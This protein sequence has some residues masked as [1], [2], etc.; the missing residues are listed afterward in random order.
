MSFHGVLCS[1]A[2]FFFAFSGYGDALVRI[3]TS[4]DPALPPQGGFYGY[5][6]ASTGPGDDAFR[7]VLDLAEK[8]HV[9]LFI[10][11]AKD[12]CGTCNALLNDLNEWS[13][14]YPKSLAYGKTVNGYFRGK[15][16]GTGPKACVEA[17]NFLKSTLGASGSCHIMGLYGVCG[18]GTL[19]KKTST[20]SSDYI[21]FGKW[22]VAQ[23]DAFWKLAEQ[24]PEVPLK[25]SADFAVGTNVL[26]A[27]SDTKSVYVPFVRTNN[28]EAAE[29]NWVVAT[30]PDGGVAT[31]DLQWAA[32]DTNLEVEIGMLTN[33]A[34]A[35]IDGGKVMLELLNTN[36]ISVATNW[37]HF[38]ATPETGFAN[39]VISAE[40]GK[41]NFGEWTL[42]FAAATGKVY[43]ANSYIQPDTNR[44]EVVTN[45]VTYS[46]VI[47]NRY[48]TVYT[49]DV[50]VF[51]D[52]TEV[53]STNWTF[54]CVASN[55]VTCIYT[56]NLADFGEPVTEESLVTVTIPM[57]NFTTTVYTNDITGVQDKSE[58]IEVPWSFE[59]GCKTNFVINAGVTNQFGDAET[60]TESRVLSA[61]SHTEY[62]IADENHLAGT[63]VVTTNVTEEVIELTG[64]NYYYT[65]PS[66]ETK[67][68]TEIFTRLIEPGTNQ[69]YMVVPGKDGAAA[70]TNL[71]SCE[72]S[73]HE[74]SITVTET[75]HKLPVDS[76]HPKGRETTYLDE[77]VRTE[78]FSVP[79]TI[80]YVTASRDLEPETSE[81][82]F[83]ETLTNRLYY[84]FADTGVTNECV[85]AR[86]DVSAEF[87]AT[88]TNYVHM[89]WTNEVQSVCSVTTSYD[90][91][92]AGG[93][94]AE[95]T[96]T[97]DE[98]K[99]NSYQHGAG[100]FDNP[101][102]GGREE[103]DGLKA[104]T[105]GVAVNGSGNGD[106]APPV[107]E[108][109]ASDEFGKWCEDNQ[110]AVVLLTPEMLD[111][112]WRSRNGYS[113]EK[114]N[115][116]AESMKPIAE[117]Y[118]A[119]NGTH[120]ILIRPNGKVA[121]R[122]SVMRGATGTS[123]PSVIAENIA[124]L[125]E[126]LA[127]ANA[128]A[129]ESFNDTAKGA[130]PLEYGVVSATNTL[131]VSDKVDMFKLTNL[132]ANTAVCIDAI[133]AD[134]TNAS[135]AV[136]FAD[137]NGTPVEAKITLGS[138]T[139]VWVFPNEDVDDNIFIKVT[140]YADG[141]AESTSFGG[142]STLEYTITVTNA[143]WCQ[144]G[145]GFDKS[146]VTY[147]EGDVPTDSLKWYEIP[148]YRKDGISGAVTGCVELVVDNGNCPT[149]RYEWGGTTNL[150]WADNEVGTKSVMVGLRNDSIWDGDGEM[151]FRLKVLTDGVSTNGSAEL[152]LKYEEDEVESIGELVVTRTDP[153]VMYNGL[154]YVA[155]G[156]ESSIY[157][158]RKHGSCSNMVGV[159]SA[160]DTGVVWRTSESIEWKQKVVDEKYATFKAPSL[161][162]GKSTYYDFSVTLTNSLDRKAK[163]T[164]K[165]RLVSELAPEFETNKVC[166]S[167][168]QYVSFRQ[169]VKVNIDESNVKSISAAKI[170][171]SMPSGLKVSYDSAEK[172][173][174]VSGTPT[175]PGN[176]VATY[177]LK[178]AMKDGGTVY[179]LPVDVT[180]DIQAL[181]EVNPGFDSA[182]K[183]SALPVIDTNMCRLVGLFDLSVAKN[184]RTSARYRRVGG[185]TVAFSSS[186]LYDI[187]NY[188]DSE[189]KVVMLYLRM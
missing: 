112:S 66:A 19:F 3:K 25:A 133:A 177:W 35:W 13:R 134:A 165:Y 74:F 108:L 117:E 38:V 136:E 187:E 115:E 166:W 34:P 188:G 180:I 143:P 70:T 11:Y 140:A 120:V 54:E 30:Y 64:T 155:A 71:L 80:A 15:S 111:A 69:V 107:E 162:K 163:T 185:K 94:S 129:N 88:V 44:L 16:D 182:R 139:N 27:V 49:N 116:L 48:D 62:K 106:V 131:H 73:S 4:G 114:F 176:A 179:S 99:T 87:N 6:N 97:Y 100:K 81:V 130:M 72:T 150:I 102:D 119:T 41:V 95:Y 178:L 159:L 156:S 21:T 122:L 91:F 32:N 181:A 189:D 96:E 144:G 148:V 124:R 173:L 76:E 53:V 77:G 183:W 86:E 127:M 63:H 175:S 45:T 132:P 79:D 65:V 17:Y 14:A 68:C 152:T 37:I 8:E 110:I 1:V 153:E 75:I 121:G 109:F 149:N 138:A 33:G 83:K 84:V 141:T 85:E 160:S 164:I 151:T 58:S 167:G 22:K 170:K 50:T 23:C 31:N 9:P 147:N 142:N 78:I 39:P 123:L 169:S 28:L 103:Y 57:T 184:G 56:D 157:I 104:F 174:V 98:V 172:S 51:A 89:T 12:G 29:S 154:I 135:V 113:S 128:D 42:D 36:K 126:L 171:G 7:K 105:L 67:E 82:T 47:S 145:I 18:D 24:H 161:P 2:L 168:V 40:G 93:F 146:E 5:Y 101:D 59:F 20:T 46:Y 186:G 55:R 52:S 158:E 118:G 125:D 92:L 43:E 90:E 137:A 61:S 26:Q 60:R 10:V